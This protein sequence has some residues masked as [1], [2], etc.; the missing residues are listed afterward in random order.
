M[1]LIYSY[2]MFGVAGS[3]FWFLLY[4]LISKLKVERKLAHLLACGTSALISGPVFYL[5][6]VNEGNSISAGLY[7]IEYIMPT[8]AVCYLF[9]VFRY[10]KYEK[11]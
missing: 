3:I 1:A 5:V 11:F 7:L 2:V 10:L 9:Y 6:V 8:A 4:S